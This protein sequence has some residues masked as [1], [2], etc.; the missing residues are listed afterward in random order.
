[1]WNTDTEKMA[2]TSNEMRTDDIKG[3]NSRV[4]INMWDRRAWTDKGV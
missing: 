4:P 1:M 2:R 3:Y